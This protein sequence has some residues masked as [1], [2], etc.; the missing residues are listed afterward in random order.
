MKV[1]RLLHG[2]YEWK[3]FYDYYMCLWSWWW[4]TL[5]PTLYTDEAD[6]K[7]INKQNL[8]ILTLCSDRMD[9]WTRMMMMMWMGI[10]HPSGSQWDRSSYSWAFIEWVGSTKNRGG[11]IKLTLRVENSPNSQQ[12]ITFSRDLFCW[13]DISNDRQAA[14]K[15]GT[16]SSSWTRR[17]RRRRICHR[18]ST[19]N[20]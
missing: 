14:M 17:R 5:N 3:Q 20:T 7:S 18:C 6:F 10:N 12:E 11:T 9:M 1:T 4:T 16:G 19:L 8:P 15:H 2:Y 13:H